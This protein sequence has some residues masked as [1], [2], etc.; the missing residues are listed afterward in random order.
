[1]AIAAVGAIARFDLGCGALLEGSS[2]IT[3]TNF[4]G[5]LFGVIVGVVN[6]F[7]QDMEV[8]EDFGLALEVVGCFSF[9]N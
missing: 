7:H 8:G 1:M 9:D 5:H 6:A 4:V 2:S 3:S